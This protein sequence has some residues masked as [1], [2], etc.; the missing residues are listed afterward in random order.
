MKIQIKKPSKLGPAGQKSIATMAC[1]KT[2]HHQ[3]CPIHLGKFDACAITRFQKPQHLGGPDSMLVDSHVTCAA[4]AGPDLSGQRRCKLRRKLLLVDKP[5][6]KTWKSK[7]D[8]RVRHYK[9]TKRL[10][11]KNGHSLVEPPSLVFHTE[12]VSACLF[13]GERFFQKVYTAIL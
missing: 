8:R 4:S 13:V 5:A 6:K 3:E 1:S 10:V 9:D 11:C 7:A 12:L 2:K